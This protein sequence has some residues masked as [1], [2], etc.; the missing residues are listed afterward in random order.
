LT[1]TRIQE[2]WAA[3][4][5][6]PIQEWLS[7]SLLAKHEAL[8]RAMRR[9]HE[10]NRIEDL[11]VRRLEFVHVSRPDDPNFH[12]VTALI[13]FD[14]KV[15]FVHE[16]TGAYVRGSQKLLPYQEFW[17][18]RRRDDIWLLHAIELSHESNRLETANSV[19]GIEA[20]DLQNATA[21]IISL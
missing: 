17:V 8:L 9:N 13:T 18:F 1:F 16:Q 14:A 2:C 11:L 19:T 20:V 7:L 12:E 6:K 3:R 15:Y 10:I 5:Y 21:G 4:D